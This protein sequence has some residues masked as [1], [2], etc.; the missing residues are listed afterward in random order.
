[1]YPLIETYLY[2]VGR[3]LPQNQR[4]D[5][6]DELRANIYDQLESHQGPINDEVIDSIL[7]ELGSPDLVAKAYTQETRCVIGPELVDTY[8]MVLR[9]VLI[10]VTIAYAVIGIVFAATMDYTV[11]NITSSII[12][13]LAQTWQTGLSVYAMITLIFTAVYHGLKTGSLSSKDVP[14]NLE[15]PWT[16]KKLHALK[17]PPIERDIH[18]KSES[19]G[20]IIG[21]IVGFLILNAIAYGIDSPLNVAWMIDKDFEA[22]SFAAVNSTLIRSFMPIINGLFIAKLLLNIHLLIQEK[23]T[24][25]TRIIDIVLELFGLGIFLALW[26]NPNFIDF[27]KIST[28]LAAQVV[29]GLE[30]S[31]RITRYIVAAVVSV[32]TGIT[33][34]GHAT[35][36]TESGHKTT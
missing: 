10:G 28:T 6:I 8:W 36:L 23:W 4:K 12:K 25:K 22:T 16:G 18:K 29:D 11:A 2:H 34:F 31:L 33:I 21:I 17:K 19:I 1:M 20:A 7:L 26:M 9:F 35:K 30:V 14:K 3:H 27:T 24:R 15:E 32:F 5:I 13:F